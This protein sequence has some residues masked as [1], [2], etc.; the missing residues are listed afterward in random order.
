[1]A[2]EC[3]TILHVN[4]ER[5]WRGGE[6][7]TLWL[8]QGLAQEGHRAIIVARPGQPLAERSVEA[9]LE[10]IHCSPVLEFDLAAARVLRRRVLADGVDILHAHTAHA[11]ALTALAARRTRARVVVTRRTG[12]RLHS[13][14]LT[15]WKYRHANAVIA[16]SSRVKR[17]LLEGGVDAAL[18][19]VIPDGTR[20]D[21]DVS[22]APR[23]TLGVADD[24]PLAVM[25]GALTREKDPGTFVRAVACALRQVPELR[26][27]LVGDGPMRHELNAQVESLGIGHALRLTG[28]R[29][30]AD[31]LIAASDIVVLSSMEEGLGSVL[32]DAM[33]FGKPVVA[34]TAGGIP[35]V[36]VQDE[37]GLLVAPSDAE[38]LGEA[39]ARLA[40][41]PEL[42]SRLAV[43]A[44]ERA[45][46][47]SMRE[48]VARTTAVYERVLSASGSHGAR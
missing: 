44:R 26:A 17:S 29:D 33:A 36:V 12:F 39:I 6:R 5:G 19:E 22:P 35:D 34:T 31:A 47:F 43:G 42:A 7:Q 23:S 46:R 40:G 2:S 18:V 9:G 16:V 25:V 4:T 21:R 14:P 15:R 48:V 27:L 13:N 8:A 38:A 24:A 37:T 3:L 45:P 10:T 41:D 1:M 28:Y 11:L 32:L 20:L 30:D